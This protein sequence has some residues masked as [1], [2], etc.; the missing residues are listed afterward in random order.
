M[1]GDWWLTGSQQ[2]PREVREE[3]QTSLGVSSYNRIPTSPN[4]VTLNVQPKMDSG[5]TAERPQMSTV[6]KFVAQ[7]RRRKAPFQQ[8]YVLRP[9]TMEQVKPSVGF[10][11]YL[12]RQIVKGATAPNSTFSTQEFLSSYSQHNEV[13]R[14]LSTEE[15]RNLERRIERE[16]ERRTNTETSG[17]NSRLDGKGQRDESSPVEMSR[18]NY[19][20]PMG[21]NNYFSR[22]TS[23]PTS[24]MNGSNPD[25]LVAMGTLAISPSPRGG[26]STC[27]SYSGGSSGSQKDCFNTRLRSPPPRTKGKSVISSSM[28]PMAP[29]RSS[30]MAKY[31]DPIGGAPPCFTQRLAELSSLEC[32]TIR[33]ERTRKLKR[34]SKQA[35]Q[36]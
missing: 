20:R 30:K 9:L 19:F 33:Y 34:Q 12:D 29:D 25:S 3:P 8:K 28:S 35:K 13:N 36:D 15:F 1:Q 26:G 27:I 7:Q 14:H 4:I 10:S 2:N 21:R 18:K 32:E 11:H 17:N 31:V 22:D 16:R 5:L 6:D 23:V 24:R